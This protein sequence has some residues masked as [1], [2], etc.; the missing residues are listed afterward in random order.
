MNP[1]KLNLEKLNVGSFIT[2]LK[3]HEKETVEGGV[4]IVTTSGTY[5]NS[6]DHCPNGGCT[7]VAVCSDIRTRNYC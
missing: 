7:E 4:K 5:T 6:D 1:K 3:S 2:S